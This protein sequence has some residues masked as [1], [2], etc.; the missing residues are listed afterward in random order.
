MGYSKVCINTDFQIVVNAVNEKNLVSKDI[1]NLVEDI[2]WLCLYFSN[3][4]LDFC[5]RDKNKDPDGI[6]KN[7]H[8]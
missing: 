2:K 6:A 1:I 7:A 5:G 8:M 4:V 3:F